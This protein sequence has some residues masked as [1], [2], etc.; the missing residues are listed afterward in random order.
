MK[1][2]RRNC[3]LWPVKAER[4]WVLK[5]RKPKGETKTVREIKIAM[6]LAPRNR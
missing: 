6:A 5:K 2:L 4:L 3:L 1:L